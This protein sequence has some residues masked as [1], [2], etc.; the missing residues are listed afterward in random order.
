VVK[1]ELHQQVVKKELH[2]QVAHYLH[3]VCFRKF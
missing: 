2:Q 3:F 1:K